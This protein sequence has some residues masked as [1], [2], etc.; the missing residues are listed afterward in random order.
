MGFLKFFY[1]QDNG[2]SEGNPSWQGLTRWSVWRRGKAVAVPAQPWCFCVP[3]LAGSAAVSQPCGEER[4]G[5]SLQQQ[6]HR[7]RA[8]RSQCRLW[9]VQ[10]QMPEL[11]A[12]TM[13]PQSLLTLFFVNPFTLFFVFLPKAAIFVFTAVGE[14]FFSTSI[15]SLIAQRLAFLG[16]SGLQRS[17]VTWKGKALEK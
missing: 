12:Q 13:P 17:I 1:C 6:H 15:L 4:S 8:I 16:R 9:E 2:R 11:P 14:S 5:A 7:D 10:D 3:C